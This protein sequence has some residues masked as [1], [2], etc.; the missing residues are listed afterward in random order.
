MCKNPMCEHFGQFF[1][2]VRDRA[3][4][5]ASRYRVARKRS[6]SKGRVL[7]KLKCRGC[8]QSATVHAGSSLRPVARHFRS[9]SLPFADCVNEACTNH[10]VNAF[11]QIGRPTGPGHARYRV[12]G[13]HVLI[14][15]ACADAGRKPTHFS[16]WELG[17]PIRRYAEYRADGGTC[18]GPDQHVDGVR[19][20]AG[21]VPGAFGLLP[22]GRSRRRGGI[23]DVGFRHRGRR[24]IENQPEPRVHR[25]IRDDQAQATLRSAR[26][27]C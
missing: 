19:R 17:P 26:S 7:V 15:A 21:R 23:P 20:L 12:N 11:E 16:I 22:F 6:G 27:R 10:G 25:G 8:G 14:C 13:P 2:A 4:N 18:D 3:G 24:G 5:P 1:D 9:E